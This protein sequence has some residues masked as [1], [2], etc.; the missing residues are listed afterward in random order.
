MELFLDCRSISIFKKED[1]A[2]TAM[3]IPITV[4]SKLAV[5]LPKKSKMCVSSDS[6]Q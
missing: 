1:C 5:I 6:G 4:R 2:F 3:K